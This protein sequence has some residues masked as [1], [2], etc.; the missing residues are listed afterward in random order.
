MAEHGLP[1]DTSSVLGIALDGLGYG[2]HDT[3]WGGEFL[4]ADYREFKRVA[5]L[6]P[7]AMLGGTQAIRQPWRNTYAYLM[8]ALSWEHLVEQF[9][10]LELVQFLADQPRSQLDHMLTT[11]TRSPL[12]SSAGRLFDALAAAIGV[13]RDAASYEGQAAIELEAL[14]QPDIPQMPPYPFQT[15]IDV[16]RRMRLSAAPLWLPLLRDLQNGVEPADMAARFHAGLAQAIAALAIT[17]TQQHQ[18]PQVVLSG[19]VFQNQVLLLAV[20]KKLQ[21]QGLTVL[22]PEAVPPNDGGIALGQ[23]AIATARMLSSPSPC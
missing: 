12:A 19:G 1:L 7:I 23:A 21:Q 3:L 2:T 6:E 4:V 9:G 11:G 13:C 10:D 5:Y 8:T 15:S 17:L 18:L 20:Q 16:E 14:I 22:T